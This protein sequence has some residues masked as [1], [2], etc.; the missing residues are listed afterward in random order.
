[1]HFSTCFPTIAACWCFAIGLGFRPTP[2]FVLVRNHRQAPSISSRTTKLFQ[3]LREFTTLEQLR[4]I[5]DLSKLPLPE[6]PD[7]IV[8]V[9]KYGGGNE[10]VYER[11]AR[12]NP[13]TLF[14]VCDDPSAIQTA[15]V[16]VQPTYDIFY[17][18]NRVARALSE[19]ELRDLVNRYQ[20]LNSD[21]DLFSEDAPRPWEQKIDLSAT[22]RTTN[23][24]IPGYDWNS[25]Q[26]FFDATATK[27]ENDF[28]AQFEGWVPPQD[29]E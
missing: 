12:D 18:G 9:A 20:F 28:M 19:P 13:A 22:P 23:R 6:R 24:F 4:E 10:D 26:G 29:E 5:V 8:T 27:M 2:R 15:Q 16:A 17:Q 3:I 14:L 21:L 7:G 11:I 1:M 25:D